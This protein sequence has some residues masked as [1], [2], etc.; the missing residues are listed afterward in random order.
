VSSSG[1]WE[2]QLDN[3]VKIALKPANLAPAEVSISAD[4][5]MARKL[6][7]EEDSQARDDEAMAKRL[8]QE[9][10][11]EQMALELQE[12]AEGEEDGNTKVGVKRG[13]TARGRN[14]K[15]VTS[16]SSEEEDYHIPKVPSSKTQK[17]VARRSK[18]KPEGV[19][20]GDTKGKLDMEKFRFN[21]SGS[22]G[23]QTKR[24]EKETEEEAEENNMRNK[25]AKG[26]KKRL[27]TGKDRKLKE[28]AKGKGAKGKGEARSKNFLDD[29]DE[30]S[31]DSFVAGSDED[32][33]G[34]SGSDS[35]EDELESGDS[36]DTDED[37]KVAKEVEKAI[38]IEDSSDDEAGSLDDE[39]VVSEDDGEDKVQ[40][41]LDRCAL[42]SDKMQRAQKKFNMSEEATTGGD[43]ELVTPMSPV[44]LKRGRQKGMVYQQK[45]I[46]YLDPALKLKP[47][48]IVGIN[49]LNTCHENNVNG[50]LADEMGLGKTVQTIAHLALLRTRAEATNNG[51]GGPHLVVVPASVLHNWSN[52]LRRFC[53]TLEVQVYHGSQAHRDEL[54]KAHRKQQ[55]RSKSGRG[56]AAGFDVMLTTYSYF[57]RESCSNDRKFLGKF[58][59]EYLILDEGHSIKNMRS[60]RF[61]R[62][63]QLTARFRLLLTGT[64][65]Q[66]R[67]EELLALL[68]FCMP[69]LFDGSSNQVL[70]LFAAQGNVE[71]LRSIRKILEPFILRR[72]KCDVLSQLVAKQEEVRRVVLTKEQQLCYDAVLQT[73]RDAK[74]EQQRRS[75]FRSDKDKKQRA[76][77][78]ERLIMELT[79]N[80][81]SITRGGAA[82][83]SKQD[84]GDKKIKHVF[85]ELRKAANHPLLCRYRFKG[86]STMA[87]L[88]DSFYD[89]GAFG[90]QCTKEM[91]SDEISSYSDYQLHQVRH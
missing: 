88:V 81:G 7:E 3:G 85:T 70:E 79:Q 65:V 15:A 58:Q 28:K 36:D 25:I 69:K 73:W 41:L 40:I 84:K 44:S 22:G 91:I 10:A 82:S 78:E 45:D 77:K 5:E 56:G 49:W 75:D 17:S 72:R 52:E 60:S 6:Q 83:S 19:K 35:E 64:P 31:D 9:E 1:R 39:A 61:Q 13:K 74:A 4:E 55:A 20:K 87:L 34:G 80:A 90:E 24:R 32:L 29:S 48:Q 76:T 38:R 59:F 57:E 67:L 12:G 30:E 37:E 50:V 46:K 43:G 27:Q 16:D 54:Q 26:K 8:Q 53:P 47:Y 21:Q 71:G 42:I 51:T 2:V 68:C 89:C 62:L 18:P 33:G 66:N 86:V 14:R 23:W 63:R 11:D